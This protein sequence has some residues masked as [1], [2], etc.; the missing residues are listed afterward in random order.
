LCVTGKYDQ[1]FV[2]FSSKF[3][4]FGN[5]GTLAFVDDGVTGA[6]AL[7]KYL[8]DFFGEAPV[9]GCISIVRLDVIVTDF[10]S[11]LPLSELRMLGKHLGTL[12]HRVESARIDYQTNQGGARTHK[13]GG[14]VE[15]S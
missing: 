13:Q 2:P 4:K 9:W 5:I 10:V 12:A 3:L 7:T 6:F 8:P 14:I 11:P 1:K 15:P